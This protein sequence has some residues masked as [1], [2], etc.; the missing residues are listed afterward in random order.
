MIE[1]FKLSILMPVYNEDATI[2][3]SLQVVLSVPF[4]KEVIVVDDG[5]IDQ[6][7]DILR[8]LNH[9]DLKVFF[10]GINQGK[11]SALRT[12]FAHATGDILLIQDADLEYDPSDYAALINPIVQGKADVV[13]G[14]R[15]SAHGEHRL[16]YFWHYIGNRILTLLSNLFT[17]LNQTDMECGFKVFTKEALE[18]VT[19][20]EPRFGFEPEIV[21]KMARKR[22]RI[23]EVPVSYFGRTY[24]QGKKI[25]WKDGVWAAWCI[26][27]YNLWH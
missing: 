3:E 12:A 5:S 19:I 8:S 18:G 15:F 26:V 25:G 24:E 4:N 17:N 9:P 13:F 20:N 7:A 2:R 14:T 23:Y 10:R 6:T 11:G 16:L 22:L 21:A 1:H 27:R